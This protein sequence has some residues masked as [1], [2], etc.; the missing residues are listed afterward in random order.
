MERLGRVGFFWRNLKSESMPPA[1]QLN[2][3]GGGSQGGVNGHGAQ[4]SF[5]T[6]GDVLM[7]VALALSAS[8]TVDVYSIG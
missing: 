6:N 3:S 4:L 7:Y 1:A 8:D 2:F 5:A